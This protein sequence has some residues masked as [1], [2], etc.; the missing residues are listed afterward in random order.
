MKHADVFG[1]LYIMSPCCL[2]PRGPG[3]AEPSD[4][5]RRWRP[6]KRPE[7]S[8]S[9]PFGARAQLAAAAAWAPNPQEPPLYL[10][11]PTG[12]RT[13]SRRA[14][15]V[16]GQ[17]AARLHRPVGSG[18]LRQ[19]SRHRHRRRRPGRPASRCRQAA[20]RARRYGIATRFEIYPGTHTSK[21]ADRFQNHVLPFFGMQTAHAVDSTAEG[22]DRR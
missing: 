17:R 12:R 16:G 13:S 6:S 3:P 10:D 8:A 1:S 14:G 9:L 11:L 7:D 4:S 19:L 18:N 15:Q 20:R 5:R 2:S 22:G 21:V